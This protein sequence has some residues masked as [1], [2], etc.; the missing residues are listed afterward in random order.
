LIAYI[1]GR[2][3]GTQRT[4]FGHPAGSFD[5]LLWAEID[6]EPAAAASKMLLTLA[7]LV[8]EMA[9]LNC[10]LARR[11]GRGIPVILGIIFVGG[12]SFLIW[13]A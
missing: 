11:G 1:I 13:Q 10:Q 4:V 9:L 12:L 2:R 7:V 5:R 3:L 8:G 6:L